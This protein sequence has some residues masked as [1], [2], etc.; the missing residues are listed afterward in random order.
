MSNGG[1]LKV[2][3]RRAEFLR[4]KLERSDGSPE[5]LG[6]AAGELAALKWCLPILEDLVARTAGEARDVH[7]Q[8]DH[9]AWRLV[10]TEATRA[11]GW[12]NLP[13]G[14]AAVLARYPDQ[15]RTIGRNI[16]LGTYRVP[17]L[18]AADPTR[19]VG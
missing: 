15:A 8:R 6:H 7:R 16:T 1:H 18:P 14:L 3:A 5:A 19:E 11:A 13:P 4:A 2:L 10:A 9:A 12:P 17:V